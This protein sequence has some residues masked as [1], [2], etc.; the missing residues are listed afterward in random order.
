[1][2]SRLIIRVTRDKTQAHHTL[3]L[4]L[5]NLQPCNASFEANQRGNL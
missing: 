3:I 4:D 1:M 2:I 5:N